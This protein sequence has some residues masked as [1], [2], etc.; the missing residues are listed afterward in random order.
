[1]HFDWPDSA[2]L[3]GRLTEIIFEMQARSAGVVKTN[4]GGW[5]SEK[6]LEDWPYAEVETL[7]SRILAFAQEYVARTFGAGRTPDP[8]AWKLSAWANVNRKGHFNRSHD[9]VGRFSFFSGIYYVDVGEIDEHGRADG[10]TVFENWVCVATDAAAKQG[11]LGSDVRMIPKSGR[12]VLFPAS[13]MHSVE[14][15]TGERP[16]IT[17]AFNLC[18]PAFAIPRLAAREL[19]TKWL[20]RNFRG[21]ALLGRKVPEKLLGVALIPR[22]LRARPLPRPL[23]IGGVFAHI[24]TSVS[25]AFALAAERF[26]AARFLM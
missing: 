3:D 19:E 1:M 14:P 5:Q 7:K 22:L 17:I 21:V 25:H 8:S 15:Y 10:R 16:R 4:R 24:E 12:M 18:H 9:H 20:W 2:A 13:L 26:E 23:S 11:S 6:N